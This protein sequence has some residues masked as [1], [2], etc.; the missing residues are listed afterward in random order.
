MHGA[1]AETYL[2]A[3]LGHC[4]IFLEGKTSAWGIAEIIIP[5]KNVSQYPSCFCKIIRLMY[6]SS[7]TLLGDTQFVSARLSF[8]I[9]NLRCNMLCLYLSKKTSGFMSTC[10]KIIHRNKLQIPE[11]KFE[12]SH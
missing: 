10:H 3:N 1:I 12:Y 7:D 4:G 8:S 2:R 11:T 6:H 9:I 5:S